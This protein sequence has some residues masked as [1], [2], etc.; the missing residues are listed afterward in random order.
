MAEF[1][2]DK[3]NERLKQLNRDQLATMEK[4]VAELVEK[5]N[6]D[7][8]LPKRAGETTKKSDAA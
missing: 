4:L 3:L 1:N 6:D 5:M 8:P 2:A 7:K